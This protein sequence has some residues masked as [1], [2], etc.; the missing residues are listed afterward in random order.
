MATR[1]AA[2][3]IRNDKKVSVTWTGL[4]QSTSDVGTGVVL[5]NVDGLTAQLSGTLGTGGA[6]T[7]QGSNDGTNWGTLVTA[8]NTAVVLDAIGEMFT[9]ASRPLQVRP[10]VTAGDGST[11]L[12]L[13]LVGDINGV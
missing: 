6:I 9:I 11:D 13:I 5:P 12:T 10:N 3:A 8:D 2:M 4:L 1:A 7:M